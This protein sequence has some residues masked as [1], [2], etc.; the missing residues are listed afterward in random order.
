[1]GA[2][3]QP[4]YIPHSRAVYV[5]RSNVF[6]SLGVP[7]IL[8]WKPPFYLYLILRNGVQAECLTFHLHLFQFDFDVS[9]IPS[10]AAEHITYHLLAPQHSRTSP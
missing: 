10:D 2:L 6:L 1:M 4:C 5:L 7:K 9:D 3:I 8:I